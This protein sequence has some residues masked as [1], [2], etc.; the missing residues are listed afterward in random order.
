LPALAFGKAGRDTATFAYAYWLNE[1]PVVVAG[2]DVG[3]TFER[4]NNAETFFDA[5]GPA[6]GL[7]TD[8]GTLASLYD[9]FLRGGV[10]RSGAR[11]LSADVLAEYT[12]GVVSGW[13]RSNKAPMTFGRGFM[14][15]S[16]WMPSVYGWWGTKRCFGHAGG[17]STVAFADPDRGLSV[18][19]VT[20]G[21]R[22]R[23]DI[24]KRFTPL[25]HA[26]RRA[27]AR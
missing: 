20:N 4:T 5:F 11:L 2:V 9:I 8:A 17:F 22:G 14:M 19:I 10:T 6:V 24:I 16:W 21:N 23:N 18:A 1:R 12:C 26:I 27:C 3:A 7:V 13:D 25:G 15:G